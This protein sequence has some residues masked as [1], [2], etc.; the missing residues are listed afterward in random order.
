MSG[1]KL[2]RRESKKSAALEAVRSCGIWL[3]WFLPAFLDRK[4]ERGALR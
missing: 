4:L 2:W 1:S 3:S